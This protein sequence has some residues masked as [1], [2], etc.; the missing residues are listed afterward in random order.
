MFRTESRWVWN[1]KYH[2]SKSILFRGRFVN[3]PYSVDFILMYT[4]HEI[5]IYGLKC[6][7][8]ICFVSVGAIHESP[9]NVGTGLRNRLGFMD[10]TPL[11]VSVP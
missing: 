3:R 5:R 7:H 11:E 2:D 10:N 6:M 4:Y 1:H 8:K 9:V